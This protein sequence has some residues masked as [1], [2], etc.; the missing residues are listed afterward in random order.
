[1]IDQLPKPGAFQDLWP[2]VWKDKLDID[3]TDILQFRNLAHWKSFCASVTQRDSMNCGISYKDALNL[4][5]TNQSTI[6]RKDYQL[7]KDKVKMVLLKRGLISDTIYKS[8]EYT[9]TGNG[10]ID[11]A[12]F[13][14]GLPDCILTPTDPEQ[15]F[16]YEIY[17]SISYD[18][19][20]DNST[21]Q[22]NLSKLLATLELLEN[23]RYF[24]KV[25]IVFPD[26]RCNNGKGN[27]NLLVVIP[28]F[29]HRDF[30]SIETMSAV[31]NQYSLRKFCFGLLETK[32]QDNLAS[33]YGK[34]V[35]LPYTINLGY[36]F[37][38]EGF[39]QQVVDKVIIPCAS[40]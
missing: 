26:S 24:C 18:W 2:K 4:L 36:E 22:A 33:G 40:R 10:V 29:S 1:M 11:V 30:K 38:V 17:V 34:P 5:L 31:I 9:T 3:N 28:I 21:V 14:S 25:N 35:S 6:P 39:S 7:I 32:Y 8:Y 20:V 37:D 27:P 16:F 23:E 12:R 15:Q 13:A 19:T